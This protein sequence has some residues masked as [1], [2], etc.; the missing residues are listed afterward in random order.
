MQ[1]GPRTH[2]PG[3]HRSAQP[4]ALAARVV[5]EAEVR[6]VIVA[7]SKLL[8]A[9]HAAACLY[10]HVRNRR[11]TVPIA[12]GALAGRARTRLARERAR[13]PSAGGAAAFDAAGDGRQP[14]ARRLLQ[15]RG[16]NSAP[17]CR[18]PEQRHICTRTT[19]I[20]TYIR[21]HD[22]RT[23]IAARLHAPLPTCS[24][25]AASHWMG[26]GIFLAGHEI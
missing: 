1:P 14:L 12:R 16:R 9:M 4:T 20:D 26:F 15:P 13:E 7:A 11:F 3:L 22:K 6:A 5:V 23:H 18:L 19:Y 10:A 25:A 8:Q 24:A 17:H 21:A 2:A